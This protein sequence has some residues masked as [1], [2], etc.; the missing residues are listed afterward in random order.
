[1]PPKQSSKSDD[2]EL[3]RKVYAMQKKI[4]KDARD[5]IAKE[6]FEKLNKK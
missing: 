3:M 6:E 5:K 4:E 2:P 1:M